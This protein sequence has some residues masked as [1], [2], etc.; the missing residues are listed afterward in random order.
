M[1]VEQKFLHLNS[2]AGDF[3]CCCLFFSMAK[4]VYTLKTCQLG[5]QVYTDL[6]TNG[7]GVLKGREISTVEEILSMLNIK[8]ESTL[9]GWAKVSKWNKESVK[10]QLSN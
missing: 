6:M 7:K 2:Q 9:Q 1:S 5:I 3:L 8:N 10:K 4:R